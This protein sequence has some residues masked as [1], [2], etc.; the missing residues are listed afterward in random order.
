MR[1]AILCNRAMYSSHH[2]YKWIT[3]TSVKLGWQL[4][5]TQPWCSSKKVSV[6]AQE[7]FY[8]GKNACQPLKREEGWQRDHNSILSG[9]LHAPF[10]VK[11]EEIAALICHSQ[12]LQAIN[13][14]LLTLLQPHCKVS[15]LGY[16]L[17]VIRSWRL[18]KKEKKGRFWKS[19]QLEKMHYL[20]G[21]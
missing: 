11:P 17:L 20:S 9:S 3:V 18:K 2:G 5:R 12:G 4:T 16:R 15:G 21:T 7:I 1:S 6:P 14:H 19:L 8:D 10:L 13:I